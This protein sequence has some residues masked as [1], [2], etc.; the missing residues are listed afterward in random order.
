[1]RYMVEQTN[2]N[3]HSCYETATRLAARTDR[4]LIT[5][6]AMFVIWQL[7][8]FVVFTPPPGPPRSV[9]V[10]R[11]LGLV[12]WC[13]ALLVL[14]A[15]GG[16]AFRSREV[17]EILDDELARGHRAQAY[18]NAFWAVMILGLAAY[19]AA[20]FTAIDGRLLSHAIVS[21]G[22]LVAVATRTYL[23]HR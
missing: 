4:I 12:A 16:G 8:F 3:P 11:T 22:V 10:V 17:R 23:N 9:D 7:A 20:Q 13:G 6:G 1:M 19:A 15:T 18:R 5:S 14:L 2:A 21:A